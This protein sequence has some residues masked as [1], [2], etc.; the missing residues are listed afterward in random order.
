VLSE[1]NVAIGT[2]LRYAKVSSKGIGVTK[3]MEEL[4]PP[5]FRVPEQIREDSALQKILIFAP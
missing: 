4:S 5:G 1:F 3:E 2:K